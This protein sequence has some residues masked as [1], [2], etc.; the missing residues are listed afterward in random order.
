MDKLDR[1]TIILMLWCYR[2]CQGCSFSSSGALRSTS[3][4][5]L[6]MLSR[7][8]T[9][10][11][12]I[13]DHTST[14]SARPSETGMPASCGNSAEISCLCFV[15]QST[16]PL[17]PCIASNYTWQGMHRDPEL[18]SGIDTQQ[19][20][21][22]S[23][24]VCK[25]NSYGSADGRNAKQFRQQKQKSIAFQNCLQ[26]EIER[27]CLNCGGHPVISTYD[28]NVY[29][30]SSILTHS[31]FVLTSS[32]ICIFWQSW[33]VYSDIYCG[34]SSDILS[35]KSFYTGTHILYIRAYSGKDPGLNRDN[36][37]MH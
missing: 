16:M 28:K 27:E 7:L 2:T 20:V 32:G 30:W 19:P 22:Q 13:L 11:F 4:L 26:R 8:H 6:Q 29:T 5:S 12:L 34:R 17:W 1:S 36:S 24:G 35:N 15:D 14:Y 9:A 10:K 25:A 18:W 3:S 31:I 21:P 33:N 37:D 23:Q